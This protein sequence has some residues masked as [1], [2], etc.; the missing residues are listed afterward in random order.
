MRRKLTLLKEMAYNHGAVELL[1][2]K[3][4]VCLCLSG[5]G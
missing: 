4:L 3:I 2:G 1:P 5:C